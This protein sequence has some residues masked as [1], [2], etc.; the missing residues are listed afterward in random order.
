MT[1]EQ[2]RKVQHAT[3]FVP[4]T[5][6]LADGRS[7]RIPH[8]DFLAFSPSGRTVIVSNP[9][10]TFDIIDL[11]LVTDLKVHATASVDGS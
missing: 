9:D 10:D 5:V 2:V 11:L 7:H 6:Y 1:I 8:R 3:P 4:D